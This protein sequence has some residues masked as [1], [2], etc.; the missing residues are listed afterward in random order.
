MTDKE[1]IDLY[2]ARSEEA[3][4]ET[5]KKYGGYC[6]TVTYNILGSYEDSEECV[7]DTYLKLWNLIPPHRPPAFGA[8]AARIARNIALDLCRLKGRTKRGGGLSEVDFDEV[9]GCLPSKDSVELTMDETAALKAVDAFLRSIS[10]EKRT[11]FI[12]R[13]WFFCTSAQIAK[14]LH[15]T[16]GRV[17][18]TIKR[19]R[20]QLRAYLESEGIDV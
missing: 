4:K 8:F 1:I 13:Y 5:D 10:R 15:T 18:M 14:E 2:F 3:I 7:N 16:E 12:Q 6:R 20:E 11:M 19:V 9:A 17:R